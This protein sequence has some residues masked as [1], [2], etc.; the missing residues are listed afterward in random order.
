MTTDL[1]QRA[2]LPKAVERRSVPFRDVELRASTTGADLTFT[3]YACVTEVGYEIEDW[4]GPYTEIV[5]Q[6]AFKTALKQKSDVPF[7]LNHDGIT[8]A[9]TKSGTMTLTE[10]EVGLHVAARLDPASPVVQTIKSAMDRGDVDE[11]SFAFWV[12]RQEW[13]PD[14]TQRDI[15]EVKLDKGD[16]SVVNY[17]ANPNTT[18]A[19]LRARDLDRL[20]VEERRELFDRLT[21]EF[22]PKPPVYSIDES[23]ARA[24]TRV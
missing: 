9:R 7:K 22:T 23:F 5:R 8:L 2:V 4:A 1:S 10:D 18:G 20:T 3:G 12:L 24:L 13:S 11:M 16:V 14:F 21:V 17:G 6:G 19:K 15:L